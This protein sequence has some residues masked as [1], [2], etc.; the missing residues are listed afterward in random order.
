MHKSP[1]KHQPIWIQVFPFPMFLVILKLAFIEVSIPIIVHPLPMHFVIKKLAFIEL[2]VR[3]LISASPV[4]LALSPF[5][6][7]V[8]PIWMSHLPKTISEPVLEH[9]FIDFTW[10]QDQS[11][12]SMVLIIL[13][14]SPVL[15]AICM[16]VDSKPLSLFLDKLA[17]ENI[18]IWVPKCA[19]A[20]DQVLVKLS[21]VLSPV[22]PCL[23]SS[24]VS[25][26][27]LGFTS[28]CLSIWKYLDFLIYK[29]LS[30]LFEIS[31]L[32]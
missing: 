27:S 11:A 26:A 29:F 21:N 31:I 22:W 3:P 24:A 28:I 23:D 18:P 19:E 32:S 9:A 13:P 8:C 30:L 20:V 4:H 10:R 15:L 16:N 7:V 17:F 1:F 2:A 14:F 5:P 25:Q 6:R 12:F